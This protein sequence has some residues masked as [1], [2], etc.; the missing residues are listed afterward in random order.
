MKLL[1]EERKLTDDHIE[2]DAERGCNYQ[3]S[4]GEA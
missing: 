1:D 3:D 2:F 4:I